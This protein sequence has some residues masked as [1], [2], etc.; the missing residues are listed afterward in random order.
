M[1]A[2]QYKKHR[3]KLGLTQS[4]LA[5]RTGVTKKTISWRERNV[6]KITKSAEI[7]IKS[8]R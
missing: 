4:Q 1:T 6:T 3:I 8:L 7:M 5:E 2:E